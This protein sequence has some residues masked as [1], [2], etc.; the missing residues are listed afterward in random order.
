[1]A[2]AAPSVFG[3]HIFYCAAHQNKSLRVFHLV[4]IF[5]HHG[6][7]KPEIL[8]LSKTPK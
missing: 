7:E 2:E 6:C 5:L 3:G 1:M 4:E 8:L